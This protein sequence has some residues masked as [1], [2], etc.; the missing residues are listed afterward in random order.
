MT[1]NTI[2][3]QYRG[4]THLFD[5]IYRLNIWAVV[6]TSH[7]EFRKRM[8]QGLRA[9]FEPCRSDGKFYVYTS[10]KETVGVI[11][12]KDRSINLAHECAHAAFWMMRERHIGFHDDAEEAFCYYQSFLYRF[13]SGEA[14]WRPR[15]RG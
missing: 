13:L 15:R 14:D 11:W 7:A 9:T 6:G 5:P 12:S 2:L 1:P 8:K 10:G 3:R 4:I